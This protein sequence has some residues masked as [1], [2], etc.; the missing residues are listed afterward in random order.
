MMYLVLC[1]IGGFH[2]L[3]A[4]LWEGGTVSILKQTLC[5]GHAIAA[6][7]YFLRAKVG[8]IALV[9]LTCLTLISVGTEDPGATT[10]YLCVLLI[11]VI[12]F[13]RKRKYK[14]S[15]NNEL[16]GIVA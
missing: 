5:L 9:V 13:M 1:V 11:L 6:G 2:H 7:T 8:H 3:W 16:E 4:Q 15:A 14:T 10:F 12:P